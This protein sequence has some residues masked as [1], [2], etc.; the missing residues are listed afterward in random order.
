ME[1]EREV[2][3]NT[4]LSARTYL[5]VYYELDNTT[6]DKVGLLPLVE[7]F[8]S[9][10]LITKE[11]L[12]ETWPDGAWEH[13]SESNIDSTDTPDLEGLV[14]ADVSSSTCIYE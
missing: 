1:S 12:A 9:I 6:D 2:D 7:S 13:Q 14:I 10:S 3:L 5:E 11:A 4:P 8:Q